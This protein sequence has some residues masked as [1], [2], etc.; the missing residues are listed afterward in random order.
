[1]Q[2]RV[3]LQL[4][5]PSEALPQS[6]FQ[7]QLRQHVLTYF[8]GIDDPLSVFSIAFALD[9]R[10]RKD[11]VAKSTWEKI[12]KDLQVMFD[13]SANPSHQDKQPN[14]S[15]SLPISAM[16]LRSMYKT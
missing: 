7:I 2:Y 10:A 5:R 8:E 1:M 15:S 12:S 9:P 16:L 4:L 14:T 3:L 6:T 13:A 11:S